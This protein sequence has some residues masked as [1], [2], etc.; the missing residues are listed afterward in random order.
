MRQIAKW[1]GIILA[2]IA[3]V[4]IS[5]PFLISVDQFR[6]R[7]QSELSRALGREV[8]LGNL[9][10]KIL[11]GE[12]MADDLSV[13]EDPAFGKP[14]FLRAKSL[15]VGVEILPFIFSRKL[16][17]TNLAIDEP[18]IVL[19]QSPSGDWNFSSLGGKSKP[20][21]AGA[22]ASASLP[23]DLS[24]QM[25]QV[26]NGRMTLRRTIG[27]WKPLALEQVNL[28]LRNFS[29]TSAFPFSLTA[30][31]H[32]GGTLKLDGTAGPINPSDSSM[33]PVKASLN[34]AQV[35]LAGSGMNDFAPQ[36]SGIVSL[37]GSGESDGGT[38]SLKGKLKGEKLKLRR[39]ATA[40]ARPAELDFAVQHNLRKHSG[41]LSQGDI[42]V[43]TA[44]AHLVGTYAE[45]GESL[46]VNL[47]LSGPAM[48]VQELE[49]MLP[50]LAVVLPAGTSL[51]GGTAAANLSIQGPADHLVSVGTL[52]VNNTRVTAF[53]LT[54]KMAAIE[55]FAGI[56]ASPDTEI[57]TLST[58]LRVAPEGITAQDVKL[59]MPSLGEVTGGGTISESNAL[60]FKLS[61]MVH[62]SGLLAAVGDRPIPF[63]VGGT[64]SDPVF[65]PDV[66]A[67][68]R[69]EVK[70]LGKGL[71]GDVG[72]TAGDLL[73]GLLGGKK[74]N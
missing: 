6:P 54:K 25:V 35:D 23:L 45:Q 1:S 8:T 64:C 13:A 68:V 65:R 4:V 73:N 66:K 26:S 32:G 28:E 18:E 34:M 71:G 7:L 49:A 63:T 19:V 38:M 20:A 57:Q 52:S 2:V 59:V 56:R 37:D 43:G 55:K 62:T 30:K 50:A 41:T 9:H 10:L 3:V 27:H 60:D 47:K 42:H 58:N 12:L 16:T 40:A 15:H 70:G 22:P 61:A 67:I 21:P 24:V 51:R 74:K 5:L 39:G 31:V 17:V 69:E 36:M 53:D 44:L 72:K 46:V 14:A 48:P 33:T 11:A 29:A